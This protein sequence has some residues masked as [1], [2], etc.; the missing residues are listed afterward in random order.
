MR[1]TSVLMLALAI[2]VG[3]GTA[4]TAADR[5]NILWITIEDISPNW[6]CYGDDYAITPYI[7]RLAARSI[8]YTR[9]FAEAPMCAPSRFTLITGMHTGSLGTSPMR[10]NHPIP[11]AFRPFPAYLREAGY[12]C[13]NNLKTDYNVANEDGMVKD[14]WDESS[15][16][17]HWRSRPQDKP[18][19]AVFNYVDTHQSRASR[20]T[21]E[22]FQRNV[23]S[24]LQPHE[25]HDPE[26]APLPP[27]YPDTP[28]ARRTVARYHDCITMLDHFVR[29]KLTELEEDGLTD[30]TIVFLFSDHGAGLPTG[31]AL[32]ADFGLRVPL[33]IHFP[34][35]YRHLALDEAGAVS[36]RLIC[37]ADFGPTVLRLAGLEVPPHMHGQP[38]LG[39][40]PG[41]P[42][43]FV[44]GTRDRMD[45]TLETTRWISDGRFMLVR[46]FDFRQ[47]LDQ[48][49]LTSFYNGNG[50]FCQE[51][52][53][54]AAAGALTSQQQHFWGGVEQPAT[55]LYDTATD[56]WC[57]DNLTSV[58]TL[59]Q[60]RDALLATLRDEM[61]DR[62]DLG[63]WPE[64]ERVNAED[65][66]SAYERARQSGVYPLERILAT[67]DLA[68]AGDEAHGELEKLLATDEHPVVR[69]WA[70]KG[71]TAYAGTADSTRD[72]LLAALDDAAPSVRI[73]AA[74]ALAQLDDAE[75]SPLALQ[76]LVNELNHRNPW[77]ACRAARA[78]ELLGERARPH[79]ATMQQAMERRSA[80]FVDGKPGPDKV[81]YGLEFSLRTAV[82]KLRP[83]QP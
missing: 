3:H 4:V 81:N 60:V 50:E 17:A 58:D 19:F 62:L 37:F 13:T 20:D 67:A 34:E 54:L 1:D 5:P 29:D 76:R 22:I 77:V 9:A 8:R 2:A 43:K 75:R 69:Y 61:R 70:A 56:P 36:D 49:T 59:A 44:H 11:A 80:G 14:A 71:L 57:L 33:L 73:I 45:E 18:F 6:G 78:L 55:L 52:R 51:L 38:F 28:I 27:H 23:Q 7:D 32:A 16:Q 48:Q 72:L 42:R 25:I 41:A 24:R 68:A 66:L 63:L 53:S 10:S 83:L 39:P 26:A 65:G 15:K 21:Y 35:K 31:K 30:D 79:L 47:P 74:E 12:H 40:D 64:P 46:R 82:K